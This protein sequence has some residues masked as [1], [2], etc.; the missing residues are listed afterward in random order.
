MF[1]PTEIL[2]TLYFDNDY[3]SEFDSYWEFGNVHLNYIKGKYAD[4]KTPYINA[5]KE[6]IDTC[7]DKTRKET[8][9]EFLKEI[10]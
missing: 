6:Y 2:Q 4:D 8:A 3:E 10:Q 1:G 5:L 7:T 9:I